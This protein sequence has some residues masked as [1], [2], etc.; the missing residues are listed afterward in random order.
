[1]L[2][3][4]RNMLAWI[5]AYFALHCSHFLISSTA[6]AD[7]VYTSALTITAISNLAIAAY[8]VGTTDAWKRALLAL[9]PVLAFV[10]LAWFTLPADGGALPTWY[11]IA[12]PALGIIGA[13]CFLYVCIDAPWFDGMAR[14]ILLFG[15]L[16]GV[17]EPAQSL[18][19]MTGITRYP[20]AASL[21][22]QVFGVWYVNLVLALGVSAGVV[23]GIKARNG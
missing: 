4:S 18:F 12:T 20:A 16:W 23:L 22:G 10:L 21:C 2:T 17:F 8:L 3:D 1:M 9:G 13:S 6:V 15:F 7:V 5:S 14:L 11:K 19:C